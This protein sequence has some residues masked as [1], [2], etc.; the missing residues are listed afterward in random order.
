[1]CKRTHVHMWHCTKNLREFLETN[2]NQWLNL[3]K[4]TWKNSRDKIRNRDMNAL[5]IILASCNATATSNVNSLV[6]RIYSY[7]IFPNFYTYLTLCQ[8]SL[9]SVKVTLEPRIVNPIEINKLLSLILDPG[10]VCVFIKRSVSYKYKYKP[11]NHC[12]SQSRWA[13]M[14]TIR[15]RLNTL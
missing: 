1:M 8:I 9:E 6:A 14:L 12:L 3:L 2:D 7:R 15:C 10:L 13:R 11:C 5:V 4:K